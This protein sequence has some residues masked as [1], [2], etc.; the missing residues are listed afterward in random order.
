MSKYGIPNLESLRAKSPSAAERGSSA[1][2]PVVEIDEG[3]PIYV[4]SMTKLYDAA[5]KFDREKN[6]DLL[7]VFSQ[8]YLQTNPLF[9]QRPTPTNHNP[10]DSGQQGVGESKL[11]HDL[12]HGD[13]LQA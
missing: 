8:S 9:T 4:A 5:W 3:D 12:A 7:K 2:A 6:G 13:E 1:V 11:S 10:T